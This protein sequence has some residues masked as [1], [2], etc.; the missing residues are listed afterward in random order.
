MFVFAIS[1]YQK[2]FAEFNFIIDSQQK[3]FVEFNFAVLVLIRK[4]EFCEKIF[5]KNFFPWGNQIQWK[6]DPS[7][8]RL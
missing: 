7:D 5:R 2:T 1:F 4:N 6:A 3:K 8:L